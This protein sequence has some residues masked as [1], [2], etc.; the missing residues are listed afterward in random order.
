M[1]Q[2]AKWKWFIDTPDG[3]TFGPYFSEPE[4]KRKLISFN[5]HIPRG[6]KLATSRMVPM[7]W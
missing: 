3:R 7:A 4:V 2:S 6:G 1:N 5:R